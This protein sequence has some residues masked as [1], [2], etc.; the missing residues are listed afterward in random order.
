MAITIGLDYRG[1]STS[2]SGIVVVVVVNK[3]T[4][5]RLKKHKSESQSQQLDKF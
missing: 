3:G 1:S 4:C 5:N 2:K